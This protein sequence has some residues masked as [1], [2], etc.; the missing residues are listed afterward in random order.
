MD[1]SQAN[2]RIIQFAGNSIKFTIDSTSLLEIMDVHFAHCLG[3]G[4]NIL[5]EYQVWAEK[6]ALYSITRNDEAFQSN[7]ELDQVL[8]QLMQDGLTQLNGAASTQL[9]FHAA[10]LAQQE[11]GVMLCGKSGSGKS[12]LTAWLTA[13]GMNYMTD[14]V[15]SVPP[16]SENFH[17]FC[18]SIVLKPGSSFIW[19]RWLN[20]QASDGFLRFADNSAW[21]EP[22]LLNP[23]GTKATAAPRL[24]IFPRYES[25]AAF[26]VERLTRA[27]TLFHLLQH[28]VNA[29]NFSDYGMAATSRLASQVTAYH[30]IYSDIEMAGK[31]IK[32]T[33]SE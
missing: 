3:V 33:A 16:E 20:N 14:E 17:G 32:Q 11:H 1:H 27:E 30:I 24:I 2:A 5:A 22:S 15:V 7:I 13:S 12:T 10:A 31:W 21:I 9:V 18:R 6:E 4:E 29:R 8:F 26:R 23:D 19:E 25:D 28:L